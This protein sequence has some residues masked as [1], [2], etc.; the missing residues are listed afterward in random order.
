MIESESHDPNAGE[1]KAGGA[2]LNVMEEAGS[3]SEM[4]RLDRLLAV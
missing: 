4:V 1:A 3:S 2:V